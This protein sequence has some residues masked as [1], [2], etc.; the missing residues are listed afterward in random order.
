MPTNSEWEQ[1]TP[2]PAQAAQAAY[3]AQSLRN[4]WSDRAGNGTI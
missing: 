3:A 1:A 2:P 4:S